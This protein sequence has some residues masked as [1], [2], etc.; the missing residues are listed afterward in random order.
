MHNDSTARAFNAAATL[1]A[2]GLEDP[3]WLPALEAAVN[4]CV[5]TVAAMRFMELVP[6]DEC[7]AAAVFYLT[8]L[9]TQLFRECPAAVWQSGECVCVRRAYVR[10]C[11]SAC[12]RARMRAWMC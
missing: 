6:T 2:V 1:A 5:A 12:V 4:R 8:C 7:D 10:A 3:L 9:D 11:V